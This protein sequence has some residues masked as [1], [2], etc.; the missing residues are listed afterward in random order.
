MNYEHQ[1]NSC[2]ACLAFACA[3]SF[4]LIGELF[5]AFISLLLAMSC[6]W[7]N[8]ELAH[9]AAEKQHVQE[10]VCKDSLAPESKWTI[11]FK[12][13]KIK[14]TRAV[15]VLYHER[16]RGSRRVLPRVCPCPDAAAMQNA[17]TVTQPRR[18]KPKSKSLKKKNI[19]I[20]LFYSIFFFFPPKR[21]DIPEVLL[22]PLP[23]NRKQS[24]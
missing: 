12:E 5:V 3:V 22:V 1:M 21:S 8:N 18:R 23:P 7:K 19:G 16:V 13:K 4:F 6:R 15:S 2:L 10:T 9:P 17:L 11:F 24:I 14:I 20:S